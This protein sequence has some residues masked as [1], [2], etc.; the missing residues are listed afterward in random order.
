M[1]AVGVVYSFTKQIAITAD[2]ELLDLE[3]DTSPES[4]IEIS[5]FMIGGRWYY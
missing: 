5:T 1:Y 4:D 3:L 2:W